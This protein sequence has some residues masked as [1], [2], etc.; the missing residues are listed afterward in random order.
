MQVVYFACNLRFFPFNNH[1]SIRFMFLVS[2]SVATVSCA[3][4]LL[5]LYSRELFVGMN[6]DFCVRH[7]L[8]K[9]L[10]GKIRELNHTYKL[11]IYLL[12]YLYVLQ[13]ST[14]KKNNN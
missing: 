1:I 11:Y 6:R 3:L 14:H 7:K 8:M 10:N 2:V 12:L 4:E 9:C 5:V 13:Q